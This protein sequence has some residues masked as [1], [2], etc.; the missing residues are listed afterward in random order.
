MVRRRSRARRRSAG[1]RTASACGP[2]RSTFSALVVRNFGARRGEGGPGQ[3]RAGDGRQCQRSGRPPGVRSNVCGGRPSKAL[4]DERQEN[5]RRE[6]V[7][8]EVVELH[9]V[10]H[11]REQGRL[12][13]RQRLERAIAAPERRPQQASHEQDG[14]DGEL[15]G[16]AGMPEVIA[17]ERDDQPL[18]DE[19]RRAPAEKE[20]S[21]DQEKR[22]Q[23][24]QRRAVGSAPGTEGEQRRRSPPRPGGPPWAGE[25]GTPR[26]LPR[27][28]ERRRRSA[29]SSADAHR[30]AAGPSCAAS[31][32]RRNG[33]RNQSAA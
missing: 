19:R 8:G 2:S 30:C 24:R 17:R 21:D 27:P 15:S 6:R 11:A 7:D 3:Q 32:S 14:R 28:T 25:S 31:V 20:R 33:S 22:A 9:V 4:R 16:G 23:Q 26:R 12:H 18:A 5:H 29:R 1:W 13:E 10:A